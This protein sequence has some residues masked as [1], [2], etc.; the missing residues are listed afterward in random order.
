M[1][2]QSKAAASSAVSSCGMAGFSGTH[3]I[4]ARQLPSTHIHAS[5]WFGDRTAT[6][7]PGFSAVLNPCATRQDR[8]Y[9]SR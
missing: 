5:G 6:F 9:A 1:A 4:P 2:S 3:T 7:A 8:A